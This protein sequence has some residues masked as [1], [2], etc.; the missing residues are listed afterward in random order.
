[1]RSMNDTAV[2][3]AMKVEANPCQLKRGNNEV[4]STL[5][6]FHLVLLNQDPTLNCH[7]PNHVVAFHA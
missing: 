3:F 2:E 4:D 7:L 5:L 6:E 1:M